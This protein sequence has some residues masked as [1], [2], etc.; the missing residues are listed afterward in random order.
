MPEESV[1]ADNDKGLSSTPMGK[2]AQWAGLPAADR[3]ATRPGYFPWDAWESRARGVG[4]ADEL[5]AL[6][7]I[8]IRDAYQHG[9]PVELRTR[10]GWADDGD[11]MLALALAAPAQ[12]GDEWERLLEADGSEGGSE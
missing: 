3:N 9:W 2:F 6:G 12:A 10:C 8:V 5:A 7:G 11:E 1:P 4:L